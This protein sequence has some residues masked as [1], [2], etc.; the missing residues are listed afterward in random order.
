MKVID[1]PIK[2][3]KVLEPKVWGD[4]RGYFF[5]SWN[6]QVMEDAGLCYD[7]IQDN[8]ALSSK[9][10]LRGLHYQ[11][12]AAGQAKLVR[13]AEGMVQDVVVDIREK[14]ETYGQ[15]FSIML[16]AENKKQLLIPRGFAHGYLV[17][18]DT[19]KFL[20]KV[21]NV[22]DPKAENG[23]RYDDPTLSIDWQLPTNNL[24]ISDKDKIL[25]F[26]KP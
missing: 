1:T 25:P 20:Y 12:G 16:S 8:E 15:S 13:V 23:I 5:E 19:A 11:Q 6:K 9:G 18:S 10:V 17:V 22:Y 7:W 4:H 2:D 21:D 24:L 26:L 14:S 3:L